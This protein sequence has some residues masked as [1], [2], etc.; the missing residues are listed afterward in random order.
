MDLKDKIQTTVDGY[1]DAFDKGNAEAVV[2]LFAENATVEDPVGSKV[3][4]GAEGLLKFYSSAMS[5]RCKITPT[6]PARIVENEAAFPFHGVVQLPD[7][8]MEFD[9]IDVMTFNDDGEI[10]TMR[11]FWGPGNT[12]YTAK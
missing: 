5:M 3:R 6:G 7:K 2:A 1:F 9:C 8:T 12:S 4:T 11:A 10:L